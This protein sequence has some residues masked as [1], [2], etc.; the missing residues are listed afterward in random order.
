MLETL[1]NGSLSSELQWLLVY[2]AKAT[3]VLLFSLAAVFILRKWSST[4]KSSLWLAGFV[5]Y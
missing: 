2:S 1:F 5:A 3:I 4:T